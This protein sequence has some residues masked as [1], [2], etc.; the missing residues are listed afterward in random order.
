MACRSC[1][2]RAAAR[3]RAGGAAGRWPRRCAAGCA[4]DPA[5]LDPA[6]AAGAVRCRRGRGGAGRAGAAGAGAGFMPGRCSG[7]N[8]GAG[9]AAFTTRTRACS[10]PRR[11][12]MDG[13]DALVTFYRSYL[14]AADTG[15]G[16]CA[17]RGLA[18]ARALHAYGA[19][20]ALAEGARRAGLARQ[21]TC[22]ACPR[23]RS[24]TP[25]PSRPT[26]TD[27]TTPFDAA[28]ARCSRSRCR[29]PAGATGRRRRA[30]CRRPISP[31]MWCCPRWTAACSPASSASSRPASAIPICNS[32]ALP[33]APIA[34]GSTPSVDRV[35]AWHRLAT[36]PARMTSGWPSCCR[37]IPAARTRWPMRSAS[38]RWPRPRRCSA[39]LGDGGLSM[40]TRPAPTR[41]GAR[42]AR[43]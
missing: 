37:P 9:Y 17:D 19:V 4:L 30:A 7:E 33:T 38:M 23:R 43:R 24:S 10:T 29:P 41:H 12:R 28:A 21:R 32:R 2:T 39:D 22:R 27:G 42:P 31:C 6:A 11:R 25:P 36:T 13:R 3:H 18:R 16:R 14:T 5:G 15:A 34:S 35:A 8:D 20:R 26:A 1:M 40:S